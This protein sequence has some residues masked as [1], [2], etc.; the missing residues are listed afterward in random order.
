MWTSVDFD[1]LPTIFDPP[2][3]PSGGTLGGYVRTALL[4]CPEL[5]AGDGAS[6]P[7]HSPC[8]PVGSNLSLGE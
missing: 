1:T 2:G 7:P 8:R 6:L 3:Q 5:Q 4:S